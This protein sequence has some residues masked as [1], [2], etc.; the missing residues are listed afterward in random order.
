MVYSIRFLK[1]K[2]NWIRRMN[3]CNACGS[4]NVHLCF[5]LGC[6]P[7]ANNYK[8]T[9][10]EYEE[11]YELAVNICD[12]CFHLQLNTIVSPDIIFKNYLY[13]TGTSDTI[14]TYFEW[15]IQ[16]V[17]SYTDGKSVFDIGCNDG[18]LLDAFHNHGYTTYGVDPAEN[19]EK[20][21]NPVHVVKVGYLDDT[22]CPVKP[23]I[24]TAINVFA[25]SPNPLKFLNDCAKIA[26]D[27]TYVFIQ[28]SQADMIVN[29]EFDTI[30]HEHVNFFNIHSMQKL[31]NRTPFKLIDVKKPN[32]HG[33]SY[34][35][36]LSKTGTPRYIPQE[37]HLHVKDTYTRWV[38]NCI[39][40]KD[41]IQKA[42]KG[43]RVIGYGAA[44]KGNTLI[45][46]TGIC[47]EVI[48]D[49][50]KLKQGTYSPG[51]SIPI[52]GIDYIKSIKTPVIFLPFAW[53]FYD[54]IVSK[55]KGIRDNEL[56]E[57]INLHSLVQGKI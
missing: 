15:Y 20:I 25:H 21:R 56:D 17:K 18:T 46:F 23:D 26:H 55:I 45:N 5:D 7:L 16:N 49:D 32:I 33:T 4:C 9:P 3:I 51:M 1:F 52:V 34:L 39:T 57:F 44:A 53:N 31:V 11:K 41:N 47:P 6:Q 42:L 38:E 2:I 43:K 14:K 36:V 35:F 37:P 24:I 50:N 54:E 19:L 28:T 48:I 22:S 40:F 8:K 10:D 30:Y 13:V 27:D 12:D 29:N